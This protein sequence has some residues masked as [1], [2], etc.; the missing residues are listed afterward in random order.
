MSESWSC[1]VFT[2]SSERTRA[3]SS[4]W[5]IGFVRK[6]SAPASMPFTRSCAGSSAVTITTGSM[7]VA[8]FSRSLRQTSYPVMPGIITSSRTRSGFS[9]STFSSAS[10]PELAVTTA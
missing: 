3:S 10:L 7:A 6:S 8:G 9:V 5:L 1:S 2:R 4:G